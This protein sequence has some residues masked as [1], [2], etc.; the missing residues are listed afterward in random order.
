[1]AGIVVSVVM[2]TALI[3]VVAVQVAGTTNISATESTLLALTTLFIILGLI[4]GVARST[5]L[6]GKR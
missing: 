1:M 5:G 6:V 4:Y 3:P 2:A